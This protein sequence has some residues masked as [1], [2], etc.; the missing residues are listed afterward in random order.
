MKWNENKKYTTV[1]VYAVVVFAICLLL[2]LII[3][4]FSDFLSFA[5]KTL[6]VLNPIL[7]GIGMAY[8]LNPITVFFEKKL[9]KLT[10]RRKP[11]KKLARYLS[12][13][14]T[15]ILTLL[16][17]SATIAIVVPQLLQSIYNILNLTNLQ[18]YTNRISLWFNELLANNPDFK[19]FADSALVSIQSYLTDLANRLQP[20]IQ[21]MIGSLTAGLVSVASA[22]KNF[23][24][25]FIIMIYLLANKE[26]FQA[27][28]KKILFAFLPRKTTIHLLE[29]WHKA[30][31]TFIGFITGKLLDSFIVG[32]LCFIAMTI[33]DMPYVLLISFIVGLTNIIPFFGPFIGAIP[34]GLLILLSNPE[35]I[36]AFIVFIILLQQFDG[37]I[38]GPKI[39]G[40][41][42][43][44]PSFWVLVAIVIGGGFFGFVGLLVCVPV[45]AVLHMLLRQYIEG[46]LKKKNLPVDTAAYKYGKYASEAS[47]EAPPSPDSSVPS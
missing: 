32:L 31:F 10:D 19:Q 46:R 28:A 42:T 27:Q 16:V 47:E 37:N 29:V 38:L 5:D 17:L 7:W 2:V 35:K 30:D 3:F 36:V 18:N 1:A 23:F 33:M 44:L 11:H 14:I 26:I 15:A 43:G 12:I 25:G 40:D 4:R 20:Q 8:I 45:F 34:S 22:I 24:I 41:S 13:A 9:K 39:L 21:S 6:R